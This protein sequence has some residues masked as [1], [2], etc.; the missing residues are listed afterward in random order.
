MGVFQHTPCPISTVHCPYCAHTLTLGSS[1]GLSR[2]C[3]SSV[4]LLSDLV[5]HSTPPTPPAE[6]RDHRG[7]YPACLT[8]H[9]LVRGL[10]RF[11]CSSLPSLS[12]VHLLVH[13]VYV[14]GLDCLFFVFFFPPRSLCC[15][16][17]RVLFLVA[18]NTDTVARI[19]LVCILHKCNDRLVAF[20]FRYL[21]NENMGNVIC[22]SVLRKQSV[23]L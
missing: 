16:V 23:I 6:I 20:L 10:D 13:S 8:W 9:F 15:T 4:S 21:G 3:C 11:L 2:C 1:V 17:T 22:T 14:V 7:N 12:H 18:V 19:M 5:S